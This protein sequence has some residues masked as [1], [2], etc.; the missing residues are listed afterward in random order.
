MSFLP[1]LGY[2]ML[3]FHLLASTRQGGFALSKAA[4]TKPPTQDG[5]TMGEIKPKP[6]SSFGDHLPI[7]ARPAAP[8]SFGQP[9]LRG[10]PLWP[11]SAVH[12]MKLT[13]PFECQWQCRLAMGLQGLW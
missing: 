6:V 10:N 2:A 3:I 12:L 1:P 4:L 11:L 9:P 5:S 7:I 8:G 13:A